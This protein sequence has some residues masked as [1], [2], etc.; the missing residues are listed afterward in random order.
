MTK[1]KDFK[2]KTKDELLSDIISFKKEL[3]NLRFQKKT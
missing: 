1:I 3:M 2:N